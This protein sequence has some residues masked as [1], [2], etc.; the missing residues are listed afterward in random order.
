M[1]IFDLNSQKDRNEYAKSDAEKNKSKPKKMAKKK[2]FRVHAEVTTFCYI[3]VE[4]NNITEANE[5]A[6]GI[7]GG[8]FISTEQGGDFDIQYSLTHTV[9]KTKKK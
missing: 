9:N 3:D 4:A 2:T 5:I 7:D 1:A 8:D 6:E